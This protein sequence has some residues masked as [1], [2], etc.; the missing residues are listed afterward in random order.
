[1]TK[2]QE[3]IR[4]TAL[5]FSQ[6]TIIYYPPN[7]GG[8]QPDFASA[9][10]FG[11]HSANITLPP[12]NYHLEN[13]SVHNTAAG[14]NVCIVLPAHLVKYSSSFDH[15]AVSSNNTDVLTPK[16]SLH[17]LHYHCYRANNPLYRSRS[18]L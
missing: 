18:H 2:Y 5:E 3:I 9:K 13:Q 1:M 11:M 12:Q 4:L 10:I 7:V 14:R 15:H 17:M 16:F 6:R 8:M